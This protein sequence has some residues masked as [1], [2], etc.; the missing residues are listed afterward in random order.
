MVRFIVLFFVVLCASTDAFAQEATKRRGLEQFANHTTQSLIG[1]IDTITAIPGSKPERGGPIWLRPHNEQVSYEIRLRL[2]ESIMMTEADEAAFIEKARTEPVDVLTDPTSLRGQMYRYVLNGMLEQDRLS[3]E[4]ER[5]VRSV[6]Q[7]RVQHRDVWFEDESA[8][9]SVEIRRLVQSGNWKVRLNRRVFVPNGMYSEDCFRKLRPEGL[10]VNGWWDG[11]VEVSTPRS[12]RNGFWGGEPPTSFVR[13]MKGMIYEGDSVADIWWPVAKIDHPI[14]F[15]IG[16]RS[17]T[18]K[19]KGLDNPD[20]RYDSIDGSEVIEDPQR[21]VD[22]LERN[23]RVRMERKGTSFWKE[24]MPD[25]FC[26]TLEEGAQ[27]AVKLPAFTF[28]GRASLFVVIGTELS[29]GTMLEGRPMFLR[30][31]DGVWWA[32]RDEPDMYGG[33]KVEH[34]WQVSPWVKGRA[35]AREPQLGQSQKIV[36]MFVEIRMGTNIFGH[37]DM[38]ALADPDQQRLLTK[39]VR[40]KVDGSGFRGIEAVLRS[41]LFSPLREGE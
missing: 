41:E 38:R 5:W 16:S 7:T 22:W 11:L 35:R 26:L 18:D 37:Q 17:L 8:Y 32:L 28:G 20:A 29:D 9:A 24:G 14:E 33:R 34:E 25:S 30:E 40:L 2:Y 6:H 13:T 3:Y 27:K 15:K 21:Y 39:T 23:M 19:D 1:E 36:R 12:I 31:C 10:A 4:D